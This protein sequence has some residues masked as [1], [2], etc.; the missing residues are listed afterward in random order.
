MEHPVSVDWGKLW[1]GFYDP[2]R[3]NN[4]SPNTTTTVLPGGMASI[5]CGHPIAGSS[6][7]VKG[8]G[9]MAQHSS[10]DGI[11][12]VAI[13]SNGDL[14]PGHQLIVGTTG[15]EITGGLTVDGVPFTGGGSSS[16]IGGTGE[17]GDVTVSAD[18][19]FGAMINATNF[20]LDVGATMF[21]GVNKPLGLK[22]TGTRS[23]NGAINL[24]GR[25]YQEP[26]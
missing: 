5:T 9:R 8:G 26:S 1:G 18:A 14:D 3:A 23:L 6:T 25:S 15:T 13:D 19:G 22:T 2:C 20:T 24:A 11:G 7:G 4:P 16:A 12:F 17:D 10:G 21:P